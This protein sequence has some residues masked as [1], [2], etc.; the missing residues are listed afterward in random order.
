MDIIRV[1]FV[2]K[3]FNGQIL[4]GPIYIADILTLDLTSKLSYYIIKFSPFRYCIDLSYVCVSKKK[5]ELLFFF[6][7]FF[8]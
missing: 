5:R 2:R 6:F 4:S 7:F 3:N 8:L 1:Q